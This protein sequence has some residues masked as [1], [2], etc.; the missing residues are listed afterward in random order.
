MSFSSVIKD[1]SVKISSVIKD[2]TDVEAPR[3]NSSV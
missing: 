1:Y 2:Y 3:C